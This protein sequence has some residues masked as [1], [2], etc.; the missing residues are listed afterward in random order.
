MRAAPHIALDDHQVT[1]NDWRASESPLIV[2]VEEP[3]RVEGTQ[4]VVPEQFSV[5]VVAVEAFGTEVH[6]DM[7]P[8]GRGGAVGV[9]PFGVPHGARDPL[10][11]DAFP[12]D[13]T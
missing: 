8:I 11:S 2:F 6:N 13:G 7:R 3:A 10:M 9:A 5:A 1:V 4:I 12:D